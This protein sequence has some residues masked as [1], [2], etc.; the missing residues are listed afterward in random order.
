MKAILSVN[1]D[2]IPTPGTARPEI[3]NRSSLFRGGRGDGQGPAGWRRRAILRLPG[4]ALFAAS[5][6]PAG[7]AAPPVPRMQ[8]L[9]LPQAISSFQLEGRELT[10]VHS[11]PAD[12][13]PFWYPILTS[14]GASLTRMGHPLDP[15]SH[16]H[17]NSVWI[18]HNDVNGIDFWGDHA[19]NQG[20][21]ATQRVDRY[22]D[23]D[24]HAAMQMTNHWLRASDHA[25]QLIE[26]RRS[27]VR[28]LEGAKSWL[29]IIDMEFAAPAGIT[30][31][32]GSTFFG[33][34]AVRMAKTIGVHDGG[35][36]ILNSE[37]HINEAR[38]FRQPARWCDYSGRITNEADGFAGIT[39]LNHPGNPQHPTAFHVR[40]DGW[41]GACLAPD[42][43]I[44]VTGTRKLRVR[45]GLWVHD[46]M[47]TQ[48]RSE[49]QWKAFTE[50]PM[51]DLDPKHK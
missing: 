23:G 46:G 24:D 14:K 13:R 48:A 2:P 3:P 4:F 19:K 36:R 42:K 16:S 38:V 9:P 50:L 18:A 12:L 6:L 27:E 37:G 51:A 10:A 28:P 35:G 11:G 20:R 8:V 33:I 40:D 30:S 39:L 32:F 21:I 17:H 49:A 25:V 34:I 31:T 15:V 29:L 1:T 41:M 26:T 7:E 45:Y 47:A 22:D 5:P 43:P 44:T